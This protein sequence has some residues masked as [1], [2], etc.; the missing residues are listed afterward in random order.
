MS[1]AVE[2]ELTAAFSDGWC[3][4]AQPNMTIETWTDKD[5]QKHPLRS[6]P[7]WLVTKELARLVRER[8]K[9]EKLSTS[10]MAEKL[11]RLG[12]AASE[13]KAEN[14]PAAGSLET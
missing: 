11:I 13:A 14:L 2:P 4:L 9:L 8:A 1:P 12:L 3:G 10:E 7:G 5:G 6:S